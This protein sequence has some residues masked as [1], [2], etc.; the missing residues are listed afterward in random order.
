MRHTCLVALGLAVVSVSCVSDPGGLSN[1]APYPVYNVTRPVPRRSAD[2]YLT[3]PIKPPSLS[4]RSGS[5]Y[6]T[7]WLPSGGRISSKWTHVVI[8]HSATG[9]GGAWRFD[10]YHRVN[11]GWDELGYH[12]VIG[13]GS[14]TPDGYVEVGP[15]WYKQKHGAHCKTPSNYYNEHG[16]GICLVG[17]FTKRGPSTKQLASLE[18]VTRFLCE[19]CDISPDHVTTHGAITGRTQC[20]GRHF[21]VK[22]LRRALV[23]PTVA[24]SYR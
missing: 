20:P 17:D 9:S 18:R 1:T 2:A 21:Q 4:G 24:T 19:R 6:P 22:A 3:R 16:V 23:Y 5:S 12:F 10:R 15:R 13:N 14:D 11:N 8:H 7:R